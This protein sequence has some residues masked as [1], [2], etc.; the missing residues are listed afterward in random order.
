MKNKIVNLM[1]VTYAAY[2]CYL[3]GT[4]TYL[5]F[6]PYCLHSQSEAACMVSTV[7]G[8]YDLTVQF[9]WDETRIFGWPSGY[10]VG[11]LFWGFQI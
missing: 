11:V 2:R 7:E 10:C 8:R 3:F 9:Y 6:D 1:K 4:S 5:Y